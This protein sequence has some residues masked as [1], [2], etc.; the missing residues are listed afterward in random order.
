MQV[1][2]EVPSGLLSNVEDRVGDPGGCDPGGRNS[3][4]LKYFTEIPVG[5]R[6]ISMAT[7][8]WEIND[9]HFHIFTSSIVELN[10]CYR[11]IKCITSVLHLSSWVCTVTFLLKSCV[12]RDANTMFVCG[13]VLFC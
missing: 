4:I 11:K 12:L 1:R 8:D 5:R 9:V 2:G 10:S 3:M 7:V 13:S 6:E